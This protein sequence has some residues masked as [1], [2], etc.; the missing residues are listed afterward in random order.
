MA[1]VKTHTRKLKSGRNVEVRPHN[2][3]YVIHGRSLTRN[4]YG[5]L[6]RLMDVNQLKHISKPE[7]E[8]FLEDG[9]ITTMK[10]LAKN[11]WGWS[12]YETPSRRGTTST[13]Y[14]SPDGKMKLVVLFDQYEQSQNKHLVISFHKGVSDEHKFES[15]ELAKRFAETQMSRN[16]KR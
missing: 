8:E 1:Q 4:Q 10:P 9:V 6:L 3:T 11:K 2:R 7:L 14:I 13:S 16:K 12:V 15:E 5:D